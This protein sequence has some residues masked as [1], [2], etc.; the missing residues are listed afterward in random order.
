MQRVNAKLFFNSSTLLS[1]SPSMQLFIFV[2][3]TSWTQNSPSGGE[4]A[5]LVAGAQ[6]SLSEHDAMQL[7]CKQWHAHLLTFIM[8]LLSHHFVHSLEGCFTDA[9]PTP[10]L[11]Y[12]CPSF[13]G[14]S[15]NGILNRI[16][17]YS[18]GCQINEAFI[19][20]DG[21]WCS[22]WIKDGK[23]HIQFHHHHQRQQKSFRQ[24]EEGWCDTIDDRLG[25]VI[26]FDWIG[27][28][29]VDELGL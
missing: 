22:L 14:L 1:A 27:S 15:A 16:D 17:A 5:K 23:V 28:R 9:T 18:S 20:Q 8:E 21:G 6:H 12:E 2:D 13:A 25:V 3:S 7:N 10:S 24:T 4:V 26:R 29:V 19:V 11:L